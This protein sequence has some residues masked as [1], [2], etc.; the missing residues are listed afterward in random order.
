MQD[1]SLRKLQ[2]VELDIL[3]KLIEIFNQNNICYYIIG[4][5]LIGATRHRGFIPWD[6]DI[7]IAIP[8]NDYEKLIDLMRNINDDEIDME[9]Y[10]DDNSLYFYPIRIV[11]K[12]YKIKEPRIKDGYANPWIDILPID[13]NPNGKIK[14]SIFKLKMQ[15][16]KLLLGLHYVDNLRDI[17]RKWYEKVI[18]KFGKIIRVGKIINPTKI[19]DKLDKTLKNNKIED[20]DVIGT[21]MGAYFFMNLFQKNY[22][23][24]VAKWNLKIFPLMHLKKCMNT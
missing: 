10:K 20:C 1:D 24:V 21:C 17:K 15:Y 14:K 4:G 3:K 8:R 12:K 11:N 18:I 2:L 5:T 16:Y 9:Y 6:D 13:G 19:K 22:S 23:E 7:D